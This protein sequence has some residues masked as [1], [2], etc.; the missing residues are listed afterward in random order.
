MLPFLSPEDWDGWDG[1]LGPEGRLEGLLDA[2]ELNSPSFGW[3]P[4][5]AAAAG[6][7]EGMHDP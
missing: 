1:L 5:V 2:G 3:L 6:V 4:A 7:D